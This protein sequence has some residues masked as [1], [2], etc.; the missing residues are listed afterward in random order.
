MIVWSP[1]CTGAPGDCRRLRGLANIEHGA[2]PH[3]RGLHNGWDKNDPKDAQVILHMLRVGATTVY[4]DPGYGRLNDLQEL[5]KTHDMVSR[6]KTELWH[7]LLTHYPAALFS[8]GRAL[9]G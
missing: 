7:R 5:S 3:P 6:A 1:P 4:S 8:G 2:R 9:P